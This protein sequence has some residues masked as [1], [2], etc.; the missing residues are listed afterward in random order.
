MARRGTNAYVAHAALSQ[1]GE[2]ARD[3][4]HG[5]TEVPNV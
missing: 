1:V 4:T 5:N 3:V 2:L